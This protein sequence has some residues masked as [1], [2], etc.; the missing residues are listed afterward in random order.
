[1]KCILHYSIKFDSDIRNHI[2][3]R[4]SI[5]YEKLSLYFKILDISTFYSR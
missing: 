3:Y 1:M 2:G 5:D 4:Y